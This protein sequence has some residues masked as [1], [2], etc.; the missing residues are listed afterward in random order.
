MANGLVINARF[1]GRR[2][3]GVERYAREVSRRLSGEARL[4]QPGRKLVGLAGHLWEQSVLPG[5]L[6]GDRL[7]SPA[8]SGPLVVARQAVTIHDVIVLEHPEW[9]P[10][11]FALWYRFFLPRLARR[12][13]QVMTVSEVSRGRIVERLGLDAQRVTLAPGGVN[14]DQFRPLEGRLSREA[15]RQLEVPE[16]Y[17]LFVGGWEPRK[18]LERLLAAW[19]DVSGLFPEVEL[20]LAGGPRVPAKCG[21]ERPSRQVRSLG[22]VD[23]SCLAELYAGA[24]AFVYPSLDEGFGLPVL[25]AMACGTPVIA[26]SAGA[27]PLVAG[28]AA[29]L[30]D[31]Y[32][33]EAIAE[34]LCLVL[35]SSATRE[36]MR[37]R[38]LAR[39]SSYSWDETAQA[40]C[41]VLDR[42]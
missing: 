7:W 10:A 24:M 35:A 26:A 17:V 25:E 40:V 11:R 42:I 22:Y 29:L 6:A 39:A 19:G 37:S 1:M 16:S 41:Q 31:P 3:T 13:E 36:N 21:K 33:V 32:R 2:I 8:N 20:V 12:A 14:P 15:R 28:D 5:A 18:N 34:A 27:I 30:V 9:Y 23:E 4:I 38:G